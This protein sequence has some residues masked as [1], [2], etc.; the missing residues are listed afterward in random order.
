VVK[1]YGEQYRRDRQRNALDE[2]LRSIA[3]QL[4]AEFRDR[5]D[6]DRQR[7]QP[8]SGNKRFAA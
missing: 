4:A 8:E 5:R 2:R 3:D 6:R 1:R 7:P